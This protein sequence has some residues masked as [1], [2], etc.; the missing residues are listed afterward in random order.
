MLYQLPN[1]KTVN[2]TIDEFLSL[3]DIDIQDMVAGNKGFYPNQRKTSFVQDDIEY[4]SEPE[5]IDHSFID[6][7]E[8]KELS[9]EE[10]KNILDNL[11]DED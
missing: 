10:I 6:I 1:G 4:E 7:E 3:S 8:E 11:P 9:P 2:L 5:L